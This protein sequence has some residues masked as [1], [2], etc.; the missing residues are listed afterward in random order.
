MSIFFNCCLLPANWAQPL[1]KDS[2]EKHIDGLTYN[3]YKYRR[4]NPDTTIAI[5]EKAY[6]LSVGINYK[7]GEG[8]ALRAIG[9]AHRYKGDLPEALKLYRESLKASRMTSDSLS[10][11]STFINIGNV[12]KQQGFYSKALEYQLKALQLRE[13]FEDGDIAIATCYNNIGNLYRVM[14]DY[15]AAV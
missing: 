12:Y 9:L 14:E 5:A 3:S 15:D 2:L 10:I 8:S 6:E 13:E 11:A 7:K 4:S 1:Q